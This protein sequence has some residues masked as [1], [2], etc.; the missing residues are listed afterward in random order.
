[1]TI[2][3][4]SI[5]RDP[6]GELQARFGQ[7]PWVLYVAG[8]LRG[9][10]SPEAIRANQ[11]R[12][13]ARARHLQDLLPQAV[14]VV[15]HTNFAFVDESGPGG[16]GVRARV[17]EACERLL[18]RCD[19]MILCGLTL[20]PGMARERAA[21]EKAG[22][23]IVQLPEAPFLG[24]SRQHH[25]PAVIRPQVGSGGLPQAGFQAPLQDAGFPPVP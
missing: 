5:P 23:P 8:P 16:L 3:R 6:W 24:L 20:S 17:L 22:M 11:A 1:M 7:G 9:D 13:M 4:A 14:L 21:A 18:L 12:M 2:A 15:P 25:R 10:G 19:G